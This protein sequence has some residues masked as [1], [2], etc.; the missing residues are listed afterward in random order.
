MSGRTA[1]V[2]GLNCKF[3]EK[4][5]NKKRNFC[6][7]AQYSKTFFLRTILFQFGVKINLQPGNKMNLQQPVE[8]ISYEVW[9]R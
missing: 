6:Y 1:A 3:S 9:V 8:N 2:F 5:L 7:F 4:N